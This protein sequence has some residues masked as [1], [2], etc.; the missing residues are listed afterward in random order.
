MADVEGA[1]AKAHQD[2]ESILKSADR[3]VDE[4]LAGSDYEQGAK[5]NADSDATVGDKA[6]NAGEQMKEST[7][8]AWES[9]K[10]K[11]SDAIET[12]KQK[13][14]D[15]MGTTKEKAPEAKDEGG[16]LFQTAGEKVKAAASSAYDS[17]DKA[18]RYETYQAKE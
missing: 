15:A 7:G 9:T 3:K 14:S 10:Q 12:T 1:K 6:S 11:T 18:N 17:V 16:S 5:T 2:A 4:A 8:S 13:A